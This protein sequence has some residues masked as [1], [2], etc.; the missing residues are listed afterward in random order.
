MH[1][2]TP[3]KLR[4]A[5]SGTPCQGGCACSS[6]APVR[7]DPAPAATDGQ[8]LSRWRIDE[9]DC[10]T[11]EG[12]IRRALARLDG[13]GALSFNLL[14]RE[15][16]V[17]HVP[18]QD[19]AIIDAIRALGMTPQPLD[20]PAAAPDTARHW[21]WL[22]LA[23]VL[24]LLAEG[25]HWSGAPDVLGAAAAVAA[26]AAAGTSTY[27][28]G[29]IA[30]RHADLNIHALMTLAVTGAF[31]IGQWP[32]AAMVMT[33]FALAERLEARSLSRARDAIGRLLTLTPATATVEREGLWCSV[34]ADSVTP[35]ERLRVAPGERVALD[36][37][38]EAGHSA[39]DQSSLTGESLPVDKEPGDSVFAGS[40][41]QSGELVCR[42]TAV[43]GDS[44]LARVIRAVEG[45]QAARAPI[46]QTVDRFA[47]IYTPVVVGLAVLLALVP[48][49]FDGGWLDWLYRAL[50]LLVIAC[51]CALVIATPVTMVSALTNAARHGI[52]VRGGAVLDAGRRLTVMAL[53]KTGTLNAGRPVATDFVPLADAGARELRSIAVA[54]AARS[55]HP[56]SR[57]IAAAAR[58]DGLTATE[59][60]GLTAL[61]GRGVRGEVDGQ[62]YW[63]GNPRLLAE[64]GVS[65]PAARI[66]ALEAGGKTVVTLSDGRQALALFAVADPVRPESRQAVN[67]LHALGIRTVMLTGDNP[68][69]ARSVATTL[70]IDD[71]RAGLLPEDKLAAIEGLMQSA[72]A[73]AGMVGDG[74]NDAPALARA[75]VGFA[76]G[77]AGS[78]TA[79]ETADVALM[80]DDPRKLA[81]FV[82]LACQAGRVLRQNLVL[83][84]GL[85]L[86]F[87]ALKVAGLGSMWM[88]VFADVGASL[89][90]IANGL[91]LLRA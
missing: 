51:P 58:Q 45:A 2:D 27:R 44:T 87:L 18:G 76:M 4:P 16:A 40:I 74:I 7:P 66:E 41:N 88:A 72:G 69:A 24:A 73:H 67:D 81:R 79:I 12:Q 59:A 80:D 60:A 28:K 50:V 61:P 84:L 90:V 22:A 77:A 29:W 34:P 65:V 36:A 49:L 13:V 26:I 75:Q 37:R 38:I 31:A 48:P 35:G 89:L 11:E 3:L 9:M 91:R 25:L 15:L 21:G 86:A 23:I 68:Q 46:Q 14:K 64:L 39:L 42:V 47:R 82:R 55:D 83:A 52:L 33:L 54:L 56:V 17:A 43:A 63:L 30:L 85:K 78:D 70:G 32:E 6:T 1:N 19:A 62:A 20:Q 53:D 8:I 10:P 57:A 71:V 5:T